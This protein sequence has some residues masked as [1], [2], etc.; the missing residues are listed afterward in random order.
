MRVFVFIFFL[1]NQHLLLLLED[2]SPCL[3]QKLSKVK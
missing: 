1:E 2:L 3:N